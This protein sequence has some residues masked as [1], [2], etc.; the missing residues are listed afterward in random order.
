MQRRLDGVAQQPGHLDQREVGTQLDRVDRVRR[1]GH[2]RSVATGSPRSRDGLVAAG[3]DEIVDHTSADVPAAV[4]EAVDVLLNLA[5]A[6][7]GVLVGL[8]RDGGVVVNTV[9]QT[10]APADEARGVRAVDV[11]VR[12]DAEQLARLVA[13]VDR[14]ELRVDVARRVPLDALAAVHAESDGGSLRGR[15]VVEVPPAR[16]N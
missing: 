9:V 3:A 8:V 4:G 6:D 12:S 2:P 5:P 13:M 11:S 14:G 15:V 16:E 10:P 1:V 7:L